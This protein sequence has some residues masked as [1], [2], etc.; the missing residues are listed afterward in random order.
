MWSVTETW[1]PEGLLSTLPAIATALLGLL[2]GEWLRSRRP[3]P[4]ITIGMLAA[5]LVLLAGGVYWG[6]LA[7]A[8]L[9]F[10]VNKALWSP[11]FV[12]LTG[13]LALAACGATYA[14]C[15]VL[16]FRRWAGP[17]AT[18]G[19]NAIAVYVAAGLLA[20]TLSAIRWAGADGKPLTLQRF[21]HEA[22]FASWL[23]P[24]LASLA[25]ALSTVLL[26]Y[27]MALWMERRGLYLKV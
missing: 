5:G 6:E 20:R 27:L 2:C 7:P 12:L 3:A 8:W 24:T 15:D 10:P 4:A 16:G 21:L 17:F 11:S 1:D 18:Y 13:G 9:L 19:R 26:F 25:W 14:V 23:P 22:L